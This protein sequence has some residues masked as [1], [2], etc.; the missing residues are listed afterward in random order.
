M[1]SETSTNPPPGTQ[2]GGSPAKSGVSDKVEVILKAVGDAPIMKQRKYAVATNRN[3]AWIL[4]FIRKYLKLQEE[5]SLFLYVNQCFA[6][7]PDHTVDSLS[8]CFGANG[9][10]VLHYSTTQ[11]WG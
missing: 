3:V 10:L 2:E 9:K 1:S 6:P 11:A 4:A 5:D 7:S 8:Q